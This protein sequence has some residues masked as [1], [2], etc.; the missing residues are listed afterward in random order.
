[1]LVGGNAWKAFEKLM[2]KERRAG[3]KPRT[4]AGKKKGR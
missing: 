3:G 1:V 2:K 4:G